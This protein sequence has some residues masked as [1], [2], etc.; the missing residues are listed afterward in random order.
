[1]KHVWKSIIKHVSCDFMIDL[2]FQK[3]SVYSFIRFLFFVIFCYF[4]FHTF[5]LN[6]TLYYTLIFVQQCLAQY[7]QANKERSDYMFDLYTFI[8]I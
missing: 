8:Q 2:D 7:L 6:D 3:K 5:S 1:M 4:F